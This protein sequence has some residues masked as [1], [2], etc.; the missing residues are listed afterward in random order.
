MKAFAR[1]GG[2]KERG[3]G[4]ERHLM[5]EVSGAL[6]SLPG[7]MRTCGLNFTSLILLSC[8]YSLLIDFSRESS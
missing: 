5:S 3:L 4:T 1:L 7:V 2:K 8:R 6:G